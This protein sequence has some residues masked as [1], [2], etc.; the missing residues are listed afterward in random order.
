MKVRF[1]NDNSF[2][3]YQIHVNY[4]L[5]LFKNAK[6]VEL[7]VQAIPFDLGPTAFRC[8]IDNKP[9]IFSFTDDPNQFDASGKSPLD[10]ISNIPIFKFHYG[11]SMKPNVIPFAP[12]SFYYWNQY[13]QLANQIQYKAK[14]L[15]RSNQ[16]SYGNATDRRNKVQNL[17]GDT[18]KDQFDSA[19]TMPVNYW[20]KINDTL[21][22]VFV[23]GYCNNM[24]DR[25]QLQYMMLG[26]CCISPYLPETLPFN[27]TLVPG[28][29][30]V[31][32]EDDYSNL[33]E[34]IEWVRSNP[35][36]AISIG[37][38]AKYKLQSCCTPDTL[39]KWIK[40]SI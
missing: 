33:I 23:P 39:V 26:C 30:Y 16:S 9:V 24:L 38:N 10:Q 1:P 27:T 29:D 25:G 34:K 21:V 8:Y 5:N 4:I 40:E 32:C 31:A 14:G 28:I 17:L 35:T 15:I 2:H 13:F 11:T 19:I 36:A 6:N 12:V 7:E 22:S 20:E 3:Y 37:Q 18:Y